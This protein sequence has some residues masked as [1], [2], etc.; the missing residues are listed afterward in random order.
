M[1]SS[2]SHNP[3][4]YYTLYSK[5]AIETILG[6]AYKQI[7]RIEVWADVL[8]ILIEGKRPKFYSKKPFINLFVQKRKSKNL[9]VQD[10][11]NT[12]FRVISEGVSSKKTAGEDS[13]KISLWSNKAICECRDY[14]EMAEKARQEMPP[15]EA[16]LFNYGTC[17]HGLSLLNFL[18]FGSLAE[19]IQ[20]TD[21]IDWIGTQANEIRRFLEYAAADF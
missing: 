10:F 18:G 14:R 1:K 21:H 6:I 15:A 9:P 7:R 4:D 11:G 5:S 17:K 20:K 3:G 16:K 8:W 19:Y 13:Y 2:F 12:I